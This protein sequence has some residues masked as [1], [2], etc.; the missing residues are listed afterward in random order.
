MR[1]G[2]ASTGL[3]ALGVAVFVAS[4]VIVGSDTV[5]ASGPVVTYPASETA[6]V[7]AEV[8]AEVSVEYDAAGETHVTLTVAGL[9]PVTRYLGRAHLGGCTRSSAELGEIFQLA[10]NPDPVR[11]PEDR[12]FRNDVNEIWL[13]LDTDERGRARVRATQPWQFHPLAR[14]GSV[15]IHDMLL[16]RRPV[17]PVVGAALVCVEVPF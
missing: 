11:R 4:P 7:S 2:P 17:D 6:G 9:A 3:A 10:T 16:Q 15:I 14:P 5:H 8:S 12:R 1:L 13:D